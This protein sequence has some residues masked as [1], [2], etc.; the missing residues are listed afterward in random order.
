MQLLFP[1][2]EDQVDNVSVIS[3]LCPS[4][5]LHLLTPTPTPQVFLQ[6]RIFF[7]NLWYTGDI[8]E[9]YFPERKWKWI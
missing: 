8:W 2:N 6:N 5:A 3:S 9:A 4:T 7:M 1:P